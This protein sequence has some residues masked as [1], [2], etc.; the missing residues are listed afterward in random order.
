MEGLIAEMIVYSTSFD[1]IKPTKKLF[2]I[3]R[4]NCKK[5]NL[6]NVFRE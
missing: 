3:Y 2:S 4:L 1:I 5:L 6:I